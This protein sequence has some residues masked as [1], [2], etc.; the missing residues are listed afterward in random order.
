ML[1]VASSEFKTKIGAGSRAAELTPDCDQAELA[2]KH[3]LKETISLVQ[4][5]LVEGFKFTL[6]FI[7]SAHAIKPSSV[8]PH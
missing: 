3:I 6:G 4:V 1:I 7:T 8:S 5:R 2:D